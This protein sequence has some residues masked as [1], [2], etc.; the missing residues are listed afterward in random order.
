MEV[1][2]K[3]W[4]CLIEFREYMNGRTAIQL[5][6]AV[7]GE[8]ML[9][10]TVNLPEDELESDEVFIKDWSENSGVY[11]VLVE[12]GVIKKFHGFVNLGGVNAYRCKLLRRE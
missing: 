6:H 10:A 12:A 1:Q 9:V 11:D 4:L 5:V 3:K 8:P 2:F 7:D